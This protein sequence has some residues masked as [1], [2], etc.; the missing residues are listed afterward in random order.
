MG[1]GGVT[2]EECIMGR[3]GDHLRGMC[4]GGGGGDH[5]RGM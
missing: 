4:R 2:S 3:G 5:L 1:G